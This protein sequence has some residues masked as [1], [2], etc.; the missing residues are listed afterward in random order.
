MIQRALAVMKAAREVPVHPVTA[1][2]GAVCVVLGATF[3][4]RY[5]AQ[6]QAGLAHAW[7]VLRLAE[8]DTQMLE[9][10]WAEVDRRRDAAGGV[11]PAPDDLDPIGR[12][13]QAD[14]L[15]DEEADRA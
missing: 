5:V 11:Y 6:Q 9:K 4:Q 14:E 10:R 13:D 1:I 7:N 15:V 3:V 8:H 12:G 2:A